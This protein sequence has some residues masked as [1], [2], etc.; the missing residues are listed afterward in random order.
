VWRVKEIAGAL[1]Q[2]RITG[3]RV[4]G[5]VGLIWLQCFHGYNIGKGDPKGPAPTDDSLRVFRGGC[6]R[7]ESIYHRSARR[8]RGGQAGGGVSVGIRL[9]A[10]VW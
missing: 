10:A 6:W 7:N 9:A 2:E 8:Y 1:R 4:F 3:G 5:G